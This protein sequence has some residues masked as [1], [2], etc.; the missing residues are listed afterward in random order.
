[1]TFTLVVLDARAAA[2]AAARALAAYD[3]VQDRLAALD[4]ASEPAG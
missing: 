3:D 2:P 4:A 1:V